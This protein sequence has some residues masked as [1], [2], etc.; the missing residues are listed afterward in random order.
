MHWLRKHLSS[1]LVSP[2]SERALSCSHQ[3]IKY[4]DLA[5]FH[6]IGNRYIG[7]RQ[8]GIAL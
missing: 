3:T 4:V 6:F 5:Y 8:S 7:S 2:A 1:L